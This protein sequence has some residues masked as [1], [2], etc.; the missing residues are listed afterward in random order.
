MSKIPRITDAEWKIMEAVW[1]DPPV[2]AQQVLDAVG[3]DEGW[4]PQTVKTLLGRLVKKG[5][6]TYEPEANRYLYSPSFTREAAVSAEAGSFIERITRGSV[7]P[8][9]AHL[10]RSRKRMSAEELAALRKLLDG[11]E[12]GPK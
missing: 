4:K 9:L 11:E 3:R 8:L 10:V 5:A 12:G 7:T 6:L 2:T 1:E